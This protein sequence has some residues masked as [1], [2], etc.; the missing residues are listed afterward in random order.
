MAAEEYTLVL[1]FD[2]GYL[3][4]EMVGEILERHLQI[5]AYVYCK[6]LF[7]FVVENGGS[8][9]KRLQIDIYAL[10]ENYDVGELTNK[11]NWIASKKNPA[12]PLTKKQFSDNNPLLQL[13][14]E[15]LLDIYRFGW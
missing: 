15:V 11:L 9:E 14:K 2:H 5:D 8:T 10:R 6:T 7:D 1:A 4:R 12:D 13:M 3:T